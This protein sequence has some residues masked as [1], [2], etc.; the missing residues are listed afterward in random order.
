MNRVFFSATIVSSIILFSGCAGVV[1]NS[2]PKVIHLDHQHVLQDKIIK[3]NFPQI[4]EVSKQELK[5]DFNVIHSS[6]T[7]TN[8]DIPG[9]FHL[10]E[11]YYVKRLNEQITNMSKYAP[12]KA[13][14]EGAITQMAGLKVEPKDHQ[15]LLNY[16]N[17]EINNNS[18]FFTEFR[19]PIEYTQ[20]DM[21]TIVI[22]YPA[23]YVERLSKTIIMTDIAPLDNKDNLQND[24]N[25]IFNNFDKVVIT[26]DREYTL[27][28]EVNSAYPSLSIYANF[29]RALGKFDWNKK[30]VKSSDI[31]KN[32]TFSY[33][34]NKLEYPL[35][36]DIFPY[37]TGSKVVYSLLLDY[38]IDSKG[39][40]SLT[41]KDVTTMKNE[42]A[43][44]V[45]D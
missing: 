35:H 36:V 2:E 20:K 14:K 32:N 4:D 37:R 22:K 26:L 31:V 24:V 21:N 19:F 33:K 6:A 10:T 3:F 27:K 42:I 9:F 8:Y 44:I 25:N 41:T 7:N 1:G 16:S 17:G 38:T 12:F 39:N 40:S 43:K 34:Y 29:E 13:I 30:E 15:I 45:N 5:V 11:N 23:S 28:D 18:K